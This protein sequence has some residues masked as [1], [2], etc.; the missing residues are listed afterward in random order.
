MNLFRYDSPV[1]EFIEKVAD[2]IL[3]NILWVLCC[4]PIV[5]IGAAT[6]AKYTISMRIIRDEETKVIV[7][8]FQAFKENFKQATILWGIMMVAIGVCIMDWYWIKGKGNDI[9]QFYVVA[10]FVISVIVIC[11]CLSVFPFIARFKVTVKE[12]LKAAGIF[13]FLHF[14]Q[15]ILIA[16]LEVGTIVASIWYLRWLPLVLL[17]GT[18]SAFYFNTIL[19]V[20]EFKK[21]EDSMNSQEDTDREGEE[22]IQDVSCEEEM[23]G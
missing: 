17:F 19:C 2:F 21:I 11:V 4:I 6:T 5:T 1:M 10:V 16:L 7:P 8:F 9:S 23:N 14:I 22:M 18:T 12:A 3:L 13:S 20:K 15:L